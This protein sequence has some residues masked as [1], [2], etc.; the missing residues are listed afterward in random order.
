[1][2]EKDL[3]TL[4]SDLP[5]VFT[6]SSAV[7]LSDDWEFGPDMTSN[8]ARRLFHLEKAD[9]VVFP[10]P[11]DPRG[12]VELYGGNPDTEYSL[13]TS[14]GRHVSYRS[15]AAFFTHLSFIADKRY[16]V[17]ITPQTEDLTMLVMDV[18]DREILDSSQ[19]IPEE[20]DFPKHLSDRL[21]ILERR[22]HGKA[23]DI[24]LKKGG[25]HVIERN[26]QHS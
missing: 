13:E 6:H 18:S 3:M 4:H 7:V 19:F 24:T 15:L 17:T 11:D 5:D 12:F 1:M 2:K 8:L 9:F 25:K 20:I 23:T 21:S 16:A 14:D 26:I 10:N 22:R